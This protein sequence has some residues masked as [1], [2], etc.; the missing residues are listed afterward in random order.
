M[1]KTHAREVAVP[2][3]VTDLALIDRVDFQDAYTLDPVGTRDAKWWMSEFLLQAP[4]WFALPWI[5]IIGKA[6]LRAEVGPLRGDPDYVLGWKVI[7]DDPSA[8]VVGLDGQSD[9]RVRLVG[10]LEVGRPVIS[11]QAALPTGVLRVLTPAVM[12]GH[13]FFAPYLLER[14]NH[15]LMKGDHARAQ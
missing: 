12:R 11:T 3:A 7:S 4:R 10:T 9:V 13:R 1:T 14:V 6:L 5:T 2:A 15:S 8:F